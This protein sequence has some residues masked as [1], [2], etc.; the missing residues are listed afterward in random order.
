MG[1]K[2]R[3]YILASAM[4]GTLLFSLDQLIV[5]TA[6]PQIVRDLNGLAQLSW[7]FT[8][9]ML[10]S[11]IGV[12]IFGKL[13]DIFGRRRFYIFGIA[14]F[15]LGSVLAGL[16]HDM[17]QLIAFRALQ[18]IGGGA[19][20]VNS[21]AIIGEIFPPAERGRWQGLNMSMNGLATIAGPVLGGWVTDSL[22]WRWV[23]FINVPIGL[24]AIAIAAVSM[25]KLARRIAR[26]A[27]DL[28][29]ALLV[30]AGLV[31]LMLALVW[32]G[33]EYPW[34]SWPVVALLV[35]ALGTLG[36]FVLV[37]R[38]AREPIL[39]L[40]LFKNRAYAISVATIFLT[41]IGLYGAILY[42]PLFAQDVIGVSAT[43]S[44]VIL[45]PMMIGL[46]ATSVLGGQ[47]VSRTGKYKGVMIV[48][49]LV[50]VL[51]MVLFSF[52][53]SN[54][55][56]AGLALRMVVLGAG[57]GV[58]MPVLT[59]VAQSAFGAERL[60]EVT[61]GTQLFKNIGGTVS[62]A[63]LG[64]VMNSQLASRLTAAQGDPFLSTLHQLNPGGAL[65]KVDAHS[66][67]AFLSTQGQAQIR[68]MINQAPQGI[69]GQLVT[70]FDHFLAMLKSALSY[71]IGHVYIVS[72][73]LMIVALILVFVLPEIPLRKTK[74]PRA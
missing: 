62:T 57:L 36:A 73:G 53:D 30:A 47:I 69:Q 22:S 13:S 52:I 31:A 64:G 21:V 18:G 44:G 46:I 67:Q 65:T 68:A 45:M 5:A 11:T 54:T 55:T 28:A 26:P 70:Q 59:T 1:R 48:G 42:L 35:A 50:T 4:L 40:G 9:Y 72:A 63:V 29:G 12:P 71:A 7:V 27:I 25:P 15:L 34:A 33:S 20:M 24:L 74:D 16:A 38:R 10:T 32:G 23:F 51:G 14:V 41:M 19:M 3:L 58:G 43:N 6:M 56:S 61:A 49:M 60:G 2:G 39:S 66:M 17:L 8:A 37:E